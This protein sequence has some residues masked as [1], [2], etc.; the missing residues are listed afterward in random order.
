M[1][2]QI[3]SAIVS[4]M[5]RRD[6]DRERTCF[7]LAGLNGALGTTRGARDENQDRVIAISTYHERSR[8]RIRVFA[9]ADGI[10]GMLSGSDC[11][12]KAISAFAASILRGSAS[13]SE[14][15]PSA[16]AAAN[17]CIHAEYQGRGGSTIACILF[18]GQTDVWIGSV[19][20]SRVYQIDS[21]YT[22]ISLTLDDTIEAHIPTRGESLDRGRL[23]QFIGMGEGMQPNIRTMRS[24]ELIGHSI[25]ITTDGAHTLAPDLIG[26]IIRYSPDAL[27]AATRI[28]DLS[29]WLGGHDNASLALLFPNALSVLQTSGRSDVVSSIWSANAVGYLQLFQARDAYHA[30]QQTK[31][32][33]SEPLVSYLPSSIPHSTPQS[34]LPR[35]SQETKQVTTAQT[36]NK[37]ENRGNGARGKSRG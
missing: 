24:A 4:Y 20:D 11:A 18:S 21:E 10:G 13:P 17:N 28:L 26:K 2:D 27:T 29:E 14:L 9:V 3:Y 23:I 19:G 35:T 32:L 15:L 5:S 30:A 37:E 1:N 25:M 16:L 31:P 6:G 34:S 36:G 33:T 12:T 8:T 22:P 7:R